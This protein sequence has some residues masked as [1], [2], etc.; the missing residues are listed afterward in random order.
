MARSQKTDAS[1]SLTASTGKIGYLPGMNCIE[2]TA[3]QMKSLK[4][5]K[6]A[7]LLCTVN[8]K[9]TFSCGI[10]PRT[11]GGGLIMFSKKHMQAA[12]CKPGDRVKVKLV[13]DKSEYGMP[14][15]EELAEVLKQDPYGKERFDK[16]TPGKQRNILHYVNTV[17]SSQLR[18]E[19]A[20]K[21]IANLTSLPE[22]KETVRKIFGYFD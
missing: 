9:V 15:S 13:E 4:E 12:G 22:G 2:L 6:K 1:G 17:K 11:S 21:L 8:G 5:L 3:T 14:M 20:I 7:R 19:R 16:L 18:V 10:L